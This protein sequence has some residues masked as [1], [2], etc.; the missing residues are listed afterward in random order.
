MKDREVFTRLI[1]QIFITSIKETKYRSCQ[2][3]EVG[4]KQY[5]SPNNKIANDAKL[6]VVEVM[7][8]CGKRVGG[9]WVGAAWGCMGV[10][11]GRWGHIC[12]ACCILYFLIA[13]NAVTLISFSISKEALCFKYFKSFSLFNL[14][15]VNY[16]WN[17]YIYSINLRSKFCLVM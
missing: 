4:G 6:L 11:V 12:Y 7:V 17:K 3:N 9:G 8:V 2:E 13:I 1:Q 15:Y 5:W 16:T 10:L 14:L